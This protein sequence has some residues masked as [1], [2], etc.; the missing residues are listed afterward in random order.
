M[1]SR[2]ETVVSACVLCVSCVVVGGA[3][4]GR[5]F[6]FYMRQSHFVLQTAL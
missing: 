1:L 5:V 4:G 2:V 6:K 3:G